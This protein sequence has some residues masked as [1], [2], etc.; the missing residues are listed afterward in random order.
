[1]ALPMQSARPTAS[2]SPFNPPPLSAPFAW[3]QWWQRLALSPS[4]QARLAELA[5]HNARRV[6]AACIDPIGSGEGGR[7]AA[8]P[9]SNDRRFQGPAWQQWPFNVYALGFSLQQ[10]WWREATQPLPGLSPRAGRLVEFGARQMLEAMS[11]ANFPST[12]P[13]V[14]AA[15]VREGGANLLRGGAHLLDDLH[16]QRRHL[17]PAGSEAFRVGDTV[18]ATPG[19]VVFRNRL[20]ELIQYSP[21]TPSV[22][23]E[24]VLIVPAWIMKYYILDLSPDNSLVD[25]LVR[26]GHTV[27]MVSWLNPDARDQHLSLDDYLSDGLCAA[28]CT[29]D[30]IVPGRRVH[31]AGYCLGGTLLA[32]GAAAMA[33]DGVERIATLS[34]FAAQTD[35]SQPGELELF[36]DEAQL[37]WLEREMQRSGYLDMQRMAAAFT[38]LRAGDLVWTRAVREYLLGQ[39]EPLIDLM[40]WNADGTRMPARMHGEYLRALYQ[41][42]DLAHGRLLAG[43]RP[44]SLSHLRAPIFMVATVAD[45]VAPW[46]SVYQL[47]RL[48][49]AQI[50]FALTTGGHNAGVVNPP[51]APGARARRHY[52]LATRP[53]GDPAATLEPQRWRDTTPSNAGS[54]WTPWRAWL[55]GHGSGETVPPAL[56]HD[57]LDY[58]RAPGSYVRKP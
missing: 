17:P 3:M 20:I 2:A 7:T 58:G 39:R 14:L 45:H 41:R 44:V 8:A 47:H 10:A 18:A 11:P 24:P 4:R 43:G 6:A 23:A 38:L 54:W 35:F 1:M 57:G 26:Q 19:R 9:A 16:R 32:I 51:P 15:T 30:R 55:V 46:Q 31:A 37:R 28:L 52:Q 29:I 40:A 12:N 48:T 5:L 21:K 33:R 49:D 34:L 36:I 42:N 53:A 22:Q 27:F 25:W 13:D 50:T 56:G